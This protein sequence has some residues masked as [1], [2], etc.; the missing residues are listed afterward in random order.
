MMTTERGGEGERE[1]E[2]GPRK[3]MAFGLLRRLLSVVLLLDGM[4]VLRGFLASP[5]SRSVFL[6]LRRVVLSSQVATMEKEEIDP[7]VIAGLEIVKYPHPSLRARS[8][9]VAEA[10]F[11]DAEKIARRML[12]LMYE[13][14]GVGLAA[15][16][17]GVNKRLMVFNPE[18][19]KEKWLDEVIL[20]NPKIVDA[21]AGT[22]VGTEGCL[23]FPGM[24]GDVA[25]RKWIK[26]EATSTKGKTIRKKYQGWVARIFQHEYD[27]LD[28]TV[29][30]DHLPDH[31]RK[32]IQPA[33]DDLINAFAGPKDDIAL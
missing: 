23:S 28:G 12:A 15:P 30:I 14:N 1:R 24:S 17:V 4:R 18:G 7:G 20:L 26:V 3:V 2:R 9:E 11:G 27:H 13:A 5:G 16:Q 8:E 21:S 19:K 33:L 31:Q 22:D 29:Y 32:D 6:P 25:R 10:D